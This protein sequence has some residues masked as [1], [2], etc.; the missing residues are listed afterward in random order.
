MNPQNQ[1]PTK[2]K[3]SLLLRN[4]KKIL[5]GSI[6]FIIFVFVVLK[7]L[8]LDLPFVLTQSKFLTCLR[9]G[10]SISTFPNG[11]QDSCDIRTNPL[12]MCT[13]AISY[14]CNCGNS[15]CWNGK[16]CINNP[17]EIQID[18]LIWMQTDPKQCRTNPWEENW[19]SQHNN[20][21][22]SYPNEK[23]E[24]QRIIKNFFKEVDINIYQIHTKSFEDQGLN[25]QVC[26]ACSCPLGY[27]LF[28]QISK[29]D[30]INMEQYGFKL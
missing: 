13:Q 19:I 18:D 21:Y 20:D 26:E 27:T 22:N 2:L 8:G 24:D 12:T 25:P 4:L 9:G 23:I 17:P 28:V 5:I 1:Q 16:K 29:G 10:A 15:K 30:I 7:I 6:G 14:G 11:C 3:P